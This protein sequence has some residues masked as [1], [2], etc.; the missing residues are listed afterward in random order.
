MCFER[1]PA[2]PY[3]S[4]RDR[5]TWKVLTEYSWSPTTTQS[6]SFLC[7]TASSTPIRVVTKEVRYIHE[8]S[9]TLKYSMPISSLAV[10]GLTEGGSSESHA[11]LWVDV[12]DALGRRLPC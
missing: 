3:I 9:L 5:V 11:R 1:V 7:T 6:G 10:P 12:D 2:R 8:L 4:G